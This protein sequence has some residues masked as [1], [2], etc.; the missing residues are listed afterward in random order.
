MSYKQNSPSI[1][2][3]AFDCP[4]C[5]AFTTQYWYTTLGKNI[6][7]NKTP[8]LIYK[9][10]E[11]YRD[12][13]QTG[14]ESIFLHIKKLAEGM[15]I[16]SNS[17]GVIYANYNIQN[18]HISQCYACEKLALWVYDKLIWPLRII[19]LPIQIYLMILNWISKKQVKF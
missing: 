8:D 14:T 7:K 4:H 5:K 10:D 9:E 16:I 12:A 6:G 2:E 11:I 15:P 1:N 19:L 3:N 13:K 18:I 17:N